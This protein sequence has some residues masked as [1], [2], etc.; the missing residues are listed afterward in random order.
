[1]VS[2]QLAFFKDPNPDGPFLD[3]FYG[4]NFFDGT[5]YSQM[6]FSQWW[7][8]VIYR[9]NDI[10]MTRKKLILAVANKDGGAHV[11]DYLDRQ[12]HLMKEYGSNMTM[13]AETNL[14]HLEFHFTRGIIEAFIRQISFEVTETLKPFYDSND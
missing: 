4:P 7:N 1:M 3:H 9:H 12:Y 2:L 8:R 13:T 10:T 14:G 11:D 5:R 6:P